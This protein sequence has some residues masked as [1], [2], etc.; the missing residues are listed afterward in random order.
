MLIN[1]QI[2]LHYSKQFNN[3][4]VS[5]LRKNVK[6]LHKRMFFIF[7]IANFYFHKIN[8]CETSEFR[9]KNFD[10]HK[11]SIYFFQTLRQRE[12]FEN[13]IQLCSFI[14]QS[15]FFLLSSFDAHKQLR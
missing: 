8:F 6:N 13:I 3:N 11:Q 12:M 10:F 4:I 7:A 14:Q 9:V 15:G 1:T 5:H 2:R